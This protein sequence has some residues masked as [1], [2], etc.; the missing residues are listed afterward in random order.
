[1]KRSAVVGDLFSKKYLF[2]L[3]AFVVPLLV[4]V[5]PEVLMGP[6]VVGFDIMGYY[7]PTTLLWLHGDVSLWSFL[8]SA[9]LL[10]TLTSGLTLA[11]GSVIL[12]LKVLP[13]VLLGF[14]GLAI[15]G[16]A[17][18]GLGWSPKKSFLPALV[19]TLYFVALR[20]S[21]DALREELALIF[22]FAVLI[23]LV[24]GSKE[25]DKFSWKRYLAFSLALAGVVLSNQVV[26][27]LALG[28]ILF[29]VVYKM[30]RE[31]RVDAVR[32]I[33]FSLPAVLL[34]FVIFYLS[35]AVPEYRLIFGFPATSD[36]WLALFG[37]SSYPA[38][39]VSE[40]GFFLYCFLPLLPLALLSVRRFGNFQMRSWIV[41][42]LIAVFIPVVSPSDLRVLMLLI[43]PFAFYVTDA[44]SWL[45]SIH[46]KRFRVTMLRIGL[47]YL[48]LVTAVLSLGFM[49][50]PNATP[51]P[52]FSTGQVNGYINTIPSS[53]LQ[54]TVSAADCQGTV[55]ALQ[56]LKENMTGNSILLTHR[57]FYGWA[58]TTFNPNQV[59]LY[60]FGNPLNA[61]TTVAQEGYSKIYLI[62]WINGQ[63]WQDQLTVSSAFHE[64]YH[65]GEIAIYQYE[66]Q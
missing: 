5:I 14:L 45:K 9:P 34:F 57:V 37:Y 54:N 46:W 6:Y 30:V 38:M 17:R 19:G 32:L 8:A 64:I 43:Y 26:A 63:G 27:V 36:G 3:L 2:L 18:R 48:V 20:V 24:A 65:S 13:P 11:G 15:Y 31:S 28:V 40:A 41:L 44:L 61:T 10:Y 47:V 53:M 33:A 55:N 4:R 25:S 62:W 16:Y 29:T 42:I 35:P 60:E 56:W 23:L 58:L 59:F 12:A 39:L 1:M 50:L 22:F 66:A 51:F 7:V 21:W 52:Y 49:L